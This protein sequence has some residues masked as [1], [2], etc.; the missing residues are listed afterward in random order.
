MNAALSEVNWNDLLNLCSNALEEF[1]E[2][3]TLVLLQICE[4]FCPRKKPPSNKQ[5][6]LLRA[7]S[8]KKRRIKKQLDRAM[9]NP[10]STAANI[11]A[12]NKKLALAFA[13]IKDAINNNLA[14]REQQAV[15]KVKDNK[16]YF[17]SYAKKFSKQKQSISMLF[18]EENRVQSDPVE[19]ANIP[20]ILQR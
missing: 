18:D 4:I 13:D 9:A 11:N 6:H 5:C 14:Y 20:N 12:L 19:I 1:P 3:F 8:R 16:K 2:L 7:L 15:N 10:K 17:F